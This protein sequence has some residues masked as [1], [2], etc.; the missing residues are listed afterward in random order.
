MKSKVGFLP[1]KYFDTSTYENSTSYV[2]RSLLLGL[3]YKLHLDRRSYEGI[4][5][6]PNFDLSSLSFAIN[7]HVHNDNSKFPYSYRGII[8]KW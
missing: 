1:E 6:K 4:E 3:F 7:I 5:C 2:K 8:R